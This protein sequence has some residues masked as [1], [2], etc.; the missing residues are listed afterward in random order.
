MQTLLPNVAPNFVSRCVP[1]N[2]IFDRNE[3]AANLRLCLV[4]F[5]EL[6]IRQLTVISVGKCN[7]ES[8]WNERVF[9]SES[10]CLLECMEDIR[11]FSK[12]LSNSQYSSTVS[13]FYIFVFFSVIALPIEPV[14]HTNTHSKLVYNLQFKFKSF[15]CSKF[16]L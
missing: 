10:T 5:S 13:V 8:E 7:R 4:L 11:N 2:E 9:G 6:A 16:F 15:I 14:K 3:I 1:S 12:Q